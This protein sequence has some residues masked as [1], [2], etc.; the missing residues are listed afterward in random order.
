[1]KLEPRPLALPTFL[2]SPPP[3]E[4]PAA[5]QPSAA[6]PPPAA[7]LVP[8]TVADDIERDRNGEEMKRCMQGQ[9]EQ[10]CSLS[11]RSERG[12]TST[13]SGRPQQQQHEQQQQQ[14]HQQ[15]RPQQMGQCQPHEQHLG[16]QQNPQGGAERRAFPP[17][18]SNRAKMAR[19]NRHNISGRAAAGAITP[20]AVRAAAESAASR[21]ESYDRAVPLP[22]D[23]ALGVFLFS[24]TSVT[25]VDVFAALVYA[26]RVASS[27]PASS[28]SLVPPLS[29]TLTLFLTVVI[30]GPATA[31]TFA[32]RVFCFCKVPWV[33]EQLGLRPFQ[34]RGKVRLRRMRDRS[35]WRSYWRQSLTGADNGTTG[36][37]GGTSAA[38]GV[39]RAIDPGDTH[40]SWGGIHPGG[41]LGAGGAIGAGG[42]LGSVAA[43]DDADDDGGGGSRQIG[44]VGN[45]GEGREH[46]RC[47][48]RSPGRRMTAD[49]ARVLRGARSPGRPSIH[50]HRGWT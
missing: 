34:L 23:L 39:G 21:E 25:I 47:R 8:C 50:G 30:A 16:Q 36:I 18:G 24:V 12:R 38:V 4:V 32:V 9:E 31:V 13:A 48:S 11:P 17:A 41:A 37:A 20:P 22:G 27:S 28:P 29:P 7:A 42:T 40:R 45:F 14:Y 33:T 3:D 1:M 6:A 49:R 35:P 15:A 44:L 2:D 10:K 43:L 26:L 19:P 46:S 5:A